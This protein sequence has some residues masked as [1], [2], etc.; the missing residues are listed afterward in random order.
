M[1]LTYLLEALG[2]QVTAVVDARNA[3]AV[4]KQVRPEIAFIDIRQD[5]EYREISRQAGF[6]AHLRKPA[7]VPLPRA[8][9]EQFAEGC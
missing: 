9:M 2:D 5:D 8:S 4:A 3:I 7:E 1:T 6:D